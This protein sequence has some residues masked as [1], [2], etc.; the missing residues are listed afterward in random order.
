MQAIYPKY[1]DDDMREEG[2]EDSDDDASWFRRCRRK[3]LVG[4][5]VGHGCSVHELWM[6][7]RVL[8]GTWG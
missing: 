4:A 2:D 3:L 7:T 6:T 8:D 5:P 1:G